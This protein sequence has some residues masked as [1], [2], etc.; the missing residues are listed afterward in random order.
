MLAQYLLIIGS[1]IFLLLGSL[2]LV[3]TFFSNKF[4]PRNPETLELM[5]KYSPVLTKRLTLWNAWVGFNAS[6]SSGAMFIG[7]INIILSIGNF[8]IYQ[9]NY[10]LLLL[11]TATAAFYLFLAIRYWFRIPILG[12]LIATICYLVSS[13][14]IIF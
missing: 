3:Y 5:K 4:L 14:L 10:L 13:V 6:H 9:Q 2:H 1:S 8:E 11:N 12:M 7:T